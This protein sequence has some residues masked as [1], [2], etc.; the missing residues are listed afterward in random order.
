M[1][2]FFDSL[3]G[4]PGI[5]DIIAQVCGIIGML[6]S[7][8]SF[9]CKSNKI[10][11]LM[12][13]G[14]SAMFIIN[15]LLIGAF[16][17][18]F[19]N[20]AGLARGL[21]FSKNSKKLWKLILIESSFITCFIVSAILDSSTKQLLLTS[22][23]GVALLIITV[24]MW[25]GDSKKIRYVQISCASPAWLVNNFINFTIGGIICEIFNMCSSALFLFRTRNSTKQPATTK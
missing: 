19:F 23:T 15:F 3:L 21:L 12:Q 10:F 24:F 2:E 1:Q 5:T 8:L 20:V 22:L 6:F 9:Q 16:G 17:S 25:L 13:G 18:A 14:C 4:V 11:F 7:I